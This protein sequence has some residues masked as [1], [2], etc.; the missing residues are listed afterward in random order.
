MQGAIAKAETLARAR[1]L[2]NEALLVSLNKAHHE[3]VR[4]NEIIK[5]MEG[6]KKRES[7]A[8][9]KLRGA[10]LTSTSLRLLVLDYFQ[11]S[12]SETPRSLHWG[13]GMTEALRKMKKWRGK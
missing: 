8:K 3:L 6:E 11:I 1:A 5:K 12:D 4:A 7:L 2:E 13:L 10:L 9:E